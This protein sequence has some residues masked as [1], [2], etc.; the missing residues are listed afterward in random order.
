M[1][2]RRSAF[3]LIELLV[4]IAIIAILIGLLLPAVQKVREAA[5]RMQSSNNLKQMTLA[6][7]N[8]HDAQGAFP[9]VC[10]GWWSSYNSTESWMARDG[11]PGMYYA[12]PYTPDSGTRANPRAGNP[13]TG[14]PPFNN[15]Y[16]ATFFYFIL[17]YIEQDNLYKGTW[18]MPNVYKNATNTPTDRVLSRK[19]KTFIAPADPSAKDE[20]LASQNWTWD[21]V[22]MQSQMSLASYACNY[23]VFAGVPREPGWDMWRG[24]C[25]GVAKMPGISDGTS[26]TIF[27]V[28]RMMV[29]GRQMPT[30]ADDYSGAAQDTGLGGWAFMYSWD[31][32]PSL[33]NITTVRNPNASPNVTFSAWTHN[34]ERRAGGWEVPQIRPSPQNCQ[35]WRPHG[36]ST[37]GCLVAMGDGSVRSVSGSVNLAA[38]CAAVTPDGGEV[39][40]LD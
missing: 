6:L 22:L 40:N 7:H 36:L 19:V 4:V 24:W 33:M 28:E 14:S 2:R 34:D 3:T 29:C 27:L 15:W 9:P 5:A 20:V 12:G 38:W 35:R 18:A 30:H 21:S 26:N 39:A 8:A 16:D 10:A 25:G 11:I 17:P 23:R 32:G 13:D 37:G 31:R 1:T